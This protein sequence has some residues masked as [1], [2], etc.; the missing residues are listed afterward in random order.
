MKR[1]GVVAFVALGVGL[2]PTFAFAQSVD[3][4]L[5]YTINKLNNY[6]TPI[7]NPVLILTINVG[8]GGG[9]AQAYAFDTGS[10]VFVAPPG[11]F[12]GNFTYTDHL[13]GY[14]RDGGNVFTGNIYQVPASA[15]KF[16]ATPGATTGGISLSTTGSYNVGSYITAPQNL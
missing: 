7:N 11:T 3:I 15:F 9:P 6:G 14:G 2:M 8:I 5:N 12:T 16:Y 13:E 10:S 4:P 1:V